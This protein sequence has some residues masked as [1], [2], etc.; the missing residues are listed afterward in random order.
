MKLKDRVAVVTGAGGHLGRAIALLLAG[1]G[2]RVVANDTD[3]RTASETAG[4]IA[5]AGGESVA[6]NADV[7]KRL[8]VGEMIDLAVG[9]WGRLDILV[10]NA[11]GPRDAKT[12]RR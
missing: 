12:R 4:M 6:H 7:T 5:A 8:E 11:G 9:R 2:A 1:E 10:N 3:L